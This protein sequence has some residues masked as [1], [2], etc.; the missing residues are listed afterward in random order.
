MRAFICAAAAA[1][2]DGVLLVAADEA[3]HAPAGRREHLEHVQLLGDESQ[4]ITLFPCGFTPLDSECLFAAQVAIPVRGEYRR[5]SK[6]ENHRPATAD[7]NAH[8]GVNSLGGVELHWSS[9]VARR[10]RHVPAWK[11]HPR[12]SS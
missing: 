9:E 3:Q 8:R 5:A 1:L 6:R 2:T 11:Q 7:I 4:D 12:A 10:E